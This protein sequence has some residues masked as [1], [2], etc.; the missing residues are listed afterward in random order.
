[1][2]KPGLYATEAYWSCAGTC[3]YASGAVFLGKGGYLL[4]EHAL[5][6][7]QRQLHE[8]IPGATTRLHT[9]PSG[10][11]FGCRREV[12]VPPAVGGAG[13]DVAGTA[14]TLPLSPRLALAGQAPVRCTRNAP[15]EALLSHEE[16]VH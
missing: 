7:W 12:E 3:G 16:A 10:F 4:S 11:G 2:K 6:I 14:L 5:F 9:S 15:W 8:L 13:G 1:M